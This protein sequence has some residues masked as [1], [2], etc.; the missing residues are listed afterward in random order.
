MPSGGEG[1]SAARSFDVEAFAAAYGGVTVSRLRSGTALYSQGEPADS[2]YYVVDGQIQLTV[3]STQ[4]KEGILG[5]LG[6]GGFC[7]EGCLIGNRLRVATAA[8]MMDSVV[9]RLERTNVLRAIRANPAMAELFVVIA[10]NKVVQLRESLISHLFDSSEQRL[11]RALLL[12]AGQRREGEARNI[13]R[14]VD[15][16]GLAQMIGTTRSRVNYFMNKFRK[17]GYVDYEGGIIFVR[18]ALAA[19]AFNEGSLD[20][21]DDRMAVAC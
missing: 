2:M 20:S 3:V 14:N 7:G 1:L 12:L 17:L 5:V 11:A 13:I 6:P 9:A 8:C 4:G 18:S 21:D 15:Q 16:E 19:V 10:L